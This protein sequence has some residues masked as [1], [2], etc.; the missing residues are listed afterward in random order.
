M[1]VKALFY[2]I[3]VLSPRG[4]ST[5][6]FFGN[7][8]LFFNLVCWSVRRVGIIFSKSHYGPEIFKYELITAEKR[9]KYAWLSPENVI[10]KGSMGCEV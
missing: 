1:S 6:R 4:L 2:R 7:H 8:D 5:S 10:L 9:L 3:I